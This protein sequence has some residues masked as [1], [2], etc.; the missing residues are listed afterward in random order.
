MKALVRYGTYLK[1]NG[2][3]EEYMRGFLERRSKP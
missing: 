3:M 2:Y 1:K